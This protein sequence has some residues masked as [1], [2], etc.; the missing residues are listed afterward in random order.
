MAR[1]KRL[2][3]I[4]RRSLVFRANR[5]LWLALAPQAGRWEAAFISAEALEDE[6]G[7]VVGKGIALWSL[8]GRLFLPFFAFLLSPGQLVL[9][10]L[11]PDCHCL[12]L[13]PSYHGP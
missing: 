6:A 8:P 3:A 7:V 2:L 10:A 13:S 1:F 11:S 4:E 9:P 5:A 12:S